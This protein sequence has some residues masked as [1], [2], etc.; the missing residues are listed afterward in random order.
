MF[1]HSRAL[2]EHIRQPVTKSG[3]LRRAG[4]IVW[5]TVTL[6]LRSL[7]GLIVVPRRLLSLREARTQTGRQ[8]PEAGRERF[9][10]DVTIPARS[11]TD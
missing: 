5:Q 7:F 8:P 6:P 10:R 9:E 3:W 11:R 1:G 2:I 4:F